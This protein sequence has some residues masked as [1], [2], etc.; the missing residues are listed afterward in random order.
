V[1]PKH[2]LAFIGLAGFLAAAILWYFAIAPSRIPASSEATAPAQV[3][4]MSW[5][6]L[7]AGIDR[8]PA[9]EIRQQGL[10]LLQSGDPDHA[11]LLFKNAAKRGDAWSARAV[12]QMYDPATFAAADFTP[13]RTAFSKPNPRKALQW[14][15]QAIEQGDQQAGALRTRLIGHL[16]EA[17]A[18]GDSTAARI[19]KR[20]E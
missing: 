10:L 8:M 6:D 9:L 3:G 11:F 5:E 20:I 19:L 16:Q 14:Y 4:P 18:A 17:A 12:G 15:Q 7:R 1:K 2:W 13:R